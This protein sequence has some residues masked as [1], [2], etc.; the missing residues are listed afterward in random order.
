MDIINWFKR[1]RKFEQFALLGFLL[2]SIMTLN[3]VGLNN[4]FNN[5]SGSEAN[6]III[7]AIKMGPIF[8]ALL[9]YSWYLFIHYVATKVKKPFDSIILISI[10]VVHFMSSFMWLNKT[11][12]IF[13]WDVGKTVFGITM[14][15]IYV[16]IVILGFLFLKKVKG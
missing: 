6:I 4:I 8:L 9:I 1:L 12:N 13:M 10:G 3:G 11:Y 14:F 7:S 5:F 15:E 16:A 2:D